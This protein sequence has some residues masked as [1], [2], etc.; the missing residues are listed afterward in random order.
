MPFTKRWSKLDYLGTILML[1]ASVTGV[2]A[3][4]SG[5][6]IYSWD[7]G[8]IITYFVV[9]SVLLIAFG[10]QQSY[11]LFVTDKN[12]TFP[13]HFLTSKVH[14]IL[15]MQTA[16]ASS[17]FLP[18]IYFVPLHFQFIRN[19]SAIQAG[20]RLLPLVCPLVFAVIMNGALMSKYG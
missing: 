3:I 5:G 14:I 11:C 12:R 6:T 1:G 16:A 8:R 9:S 20:V 19:D 10:I 15:F 7:D 17:L 2:L 13:C 18:P 4:N